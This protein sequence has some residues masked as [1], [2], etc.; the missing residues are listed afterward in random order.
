MVGGFKPLLD[1]L[2]EGIDGSHQDKLA[3][4]IGG[5]HQDK[6]AEGIGGSH[7]DKLAEGIGG[8]QP[9]GGD[10]GG[11]TATAV[12]S[13]VF[14]HGAAGC[15]V[16]VERGVRASGEGAADAGGGGLP[17]VAVHTADGAVHEAS[18]AVITVPLGVLQRDPSQSG[19]IAFAP[20]LPAW[21]QGAIARGFMGCLNKLIL[22]FESC[23]WPADQYSFGY[24]NATPNELPSMIVNLMPTHNKPIL[25]FMVGGSA[26]QCKIRDPPLA[27][28][29][30][31]GGTDGGAMQWPRG[32]LSVQ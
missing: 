6:L 5:S 18:A 12:S 15:V 29:H 20:P 26:G 1:K 14:R 17:F 22:E 2:V 24:I 23:H 13:S 28:K 30:L 3:E 31:P 25:V 32:G 11:G 27:T 16:R 8:S 10:G 7:Q 4:G 9:H 21:K 19:H